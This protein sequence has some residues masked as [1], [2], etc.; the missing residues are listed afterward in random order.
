MA[1]RITPIEPGELTRR[2]T[3][4]QATDAVGTGGF[5]VETWT[6]LATASASLKTVSARERLTRD[7]VGAPFTTR[8]ELQYR[9][10]MDPELVDVPK[11][12]RLTYQ[13]RVHDIVEASV[14]GQR[15]GIELVTLAATTI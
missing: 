12:R 8:W 1:Q 15:W 4:E 9:A 11:L 14:I 10:D 3:L 6:T 2:V 13:G 5:P 7:Q